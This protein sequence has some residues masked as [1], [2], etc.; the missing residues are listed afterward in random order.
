M[1]FS[2]TDSLV[3]IPANSAAREKRV[4]G[5]CERNTA[6]IP[7]VFP[8]SCLLLDAIP[9]T[10]GVFHRSYVSARQY[11]ALPHRPLFQEKKRGGPVVGDCADSG[12]KES[13]VEAVGAVRVKLHKHLPRT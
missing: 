6:L 12:P 4:R 9:T 3:A 13:G 11:L 2:S 8:K 10:T 1:R 5:S 7:W